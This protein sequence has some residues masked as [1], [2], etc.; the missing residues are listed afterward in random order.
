MRSV[1]CIHKVRPGWFFY[2]FNIK[3]CLHFFF[4][5]FVL[6]AKEFGCTEFVNP[7]DHDKPIQQVWEDWFLL[8]VKH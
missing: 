5:L 6:T 1:I 2:P 7:K 8:F 3:F 4:L